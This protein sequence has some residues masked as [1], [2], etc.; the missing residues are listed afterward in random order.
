MDHEPKRASTA[1]DRAEISEVMARIVAGDP[2]AV[3]TFM[4]R[5]GH[6]VRFVVRRIL[7]DMGRLDVRDDADELHGLVTDAC[8]VV[9]DRAAGWSPDGAL[10]WTW[11]Y[12]AIR[13]KVGQ[14]VGHRSIEL[15]ESL[16]DDPGTGPPV[17]VLDE[18]SSDGFIRLA[19]RDPYVRLL[20][21]SLRTV[22]ST[23]DY[24]VVLDYVV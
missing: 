3:V 19:C 23:R 17:I 1:E 2:A 15:E 22:A 18:P 9:T 24:E 8:L 16:V 11:A 4:D 13:A 12:L 7:E 5:F 14:V 10:P 20:V 21:D 6:R